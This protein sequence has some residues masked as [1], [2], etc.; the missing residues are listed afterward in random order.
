MQDI[1][2]QPLLCGKSISEDQYHQLCRDMVV[3]EYILFGDNTLECFTLLNPLVGISDPF[4]FKA[5]VHL[6]L[7]QP[8]YVFE[9]NKNI[10]SVKI[11][12]SYTNWNLPLPV[13]ELINKY[14]LPDFVLYSLSEKK[15]IFAGELTETASVG[16]SQWQRELRKIAAAELK[17]PF[18]Y[19]TTY[20]G[21]D[22]SQDTIREPTSLLVYNAMM[23]SIRYK[24]ASQVL[25]IEPNSRDAITRERKSPLDSSMA[26][27]LLAGYLLESSVRDS[28][29]RINTEKLIYKKMLEFLNEPKKLKD[30]F[31]QGSRLVKDYPCTPKTLVELIQDNSRHDDY[32]NDLLD[33]L[34]ASP[35][36]TSFPRQYP[37]AEANIKSMKQWTS[38]SSKKYIKSLFEFIEND[39][40][41]N[42]PLAP[43]S[44]FSVGII[45]SNVLIR[46]LRTKNNHESLI[47]KIS[48]YE[49]SIIVPTSLHKKSN[50][51]LSY[52]KDPYSGNIA[53]FCELLGY[54]TSGKKSRGVLVFCVS[55]TPKGFDFHTKYK[56]TL[57][58]SIA[59]Y[60]DGIIIDN[61]Q[62]IDHF[63]NDTLKY[64]DHTY[65]NLL[66][67][68][69][70]N[71]TEDS[72]LIS[73]YVQLSNKAGDWRACMI[74]IHHS[75]WQQ[76]IIRNTED[77]LIIGK[78]GRNDAKLDLLMQ[79]NENKFLAAE[80]KR[81]YEGF[82][83]STQETK[84]I[85]QAFKNTFNKIDELYGPGS[86]KITSL[87]C[88]LNIPSIKS[89]F[90][91]DQ[92]KEKINKSIESNHISEFIDGDY[93]I[94]GVYVLNRK[95]RFEL[96]FSN[97]FNHE[98]KDLI[99]EGFQSK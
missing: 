22:D 19:Q 81:S 79:H 26:S 55:D 76:V 77:E 49:E 36:N 17:I 69:P 11:S 60:S 87:I 53:A 74:S 21:K 72:S 43:L 62:I 88:M 68:K 41:D 9:L 61:D 92:E 89:K 3:H 85:N 95:T 6:P 14:D 73:T 47:E 45:K 10:I 50:E 94:I 1:L 42:Q 75:S 25:L 29:F 96:F 32:I 84:K 71:I 24:V 2:N 63:K 13:A 37:W 7:D 82:F 30:G 91:L 83:R 27:K 65:R 4:T 56:T 58:R 12:G 5:L 54:D 51:K 57:Y 38:Y 66:E 93:L 48:Q 31:S 64:E 20:S 46:Y 15:V 8:I 80:G 98:L 70:S 18:I 78:I 67:V 23:Y 33:F 44:K 16:N 28:T 97:G 34:N 59:K 86:V 99:T 40:P 39:P 90:F 35:N 52:C